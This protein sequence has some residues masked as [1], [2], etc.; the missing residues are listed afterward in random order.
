MLLYSELVGKNQ[1]IILSNKRN[2]CLI[3]SSCVTACGAAFAAIPIQLE[4]ASTLS[5]SVLFAVDINSYSPD[6]KL[7]LQK[8]SF[9]RTSTHYAKKCLA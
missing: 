3:P 2:G 4:A 8:L 6:L 7:A 5:P 1:A 9:R